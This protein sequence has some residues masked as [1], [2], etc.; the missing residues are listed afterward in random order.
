MTHWQRNE[1]IN[2]SKVV[3]TSSPVICSRNRKHSPKHEIW[4]SPLSPMVLLFSFQAV[5]GGRKQNDCNR[6]TIHSLF[7][8]CSLYFHRVTSH[9]QNLVPESRPSACWR[10][11]GGGAWRTT[12]ATALALIAALATALCPNRKL[13]HHCHDFYVPLWAD[14][15]SAKR[16]VSSLLSS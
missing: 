3:A 9:F 6:L 15:V 11:R 5:T 12:W 8:T 4:A 7:T 2:Y 1:A 14:H 10:C 13:K 16:Q